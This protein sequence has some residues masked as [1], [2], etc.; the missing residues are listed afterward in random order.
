MLKNILFVV[1][2]AICGTSANAQPSG[3]DIT[4]GK[5]ISIYSEI[6][7]EERK[8]W[9]HVPDGYAAGHPIG[10]RYPVIYLLDGE[11]HFYS[12]VGMMRQLSSVN[13][14][15]VCPKMIVVGITNTNR[16]RDLTPSQADLGQ[17]YIDSS[18]VANSGGGEKFMTFVEE[19]LIPHVEA[20]YPTQP[21]RMFIGHSFGGLT[22]LHTLFHRTEL[23]DSYV[24]I[25]PAAAW[26]DRDLFRKVIKTPIT[27]QFRDKSLYLGIAND[28]EPGMDTLTAQKDTTFSTIRIRSLLHLNRWFGKY[29]KH[30]RSYGGKFY[31]QDTHGSV[32]LIAEYDA[33][34]LFFDFYPLK[35][36]FDDY[37]NPATDVYNKVISHFEK[38]ST[39]L[40]YKVRP[41]EAF[42]N[43]LGYSF[44]NLNRL[45]IA[46]QFF[47]LNTLNYPGSFN[48]YDSLGDLY[49]STGETGQAIINYRKALSLQENLESRKKLEALEKE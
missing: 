23:F 24:A 10:K 47:R 49:R 8:I 36:T 45:D 3:N 35:I 2:F 31:D 16:T 14:N 32:P 19:E 27:D 43:M 13:G 17:P 46:E 22:V 28:L 33:L 41:E 44:L 37:T 9:V 5:V 6:M 21:Y 39:V 4:I 30:F 48:A 42:A 25:D 7:Q 40:G 1:I 20:T 26:D 12:V 11:A 29:A 15:T 38:V 18:M 34:R